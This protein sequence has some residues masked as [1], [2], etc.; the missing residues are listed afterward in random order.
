MKRRSTTADTA[1]AREASLRMGELIREHPA[2]PLLLY[3]PFEAPVYRVENN[4]RL[5]V[6]LK[7]RLNRECRAML[8][9]FWQ[10]F[11]AKQTPGVRLSIDFNPS[12]FQ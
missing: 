7:C 5:R 3:G 2:L 9:A 12:S 4:Y 8:L 1:L 6:I 10:E 11:L